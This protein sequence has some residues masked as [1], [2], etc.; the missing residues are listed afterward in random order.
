MY[1]I[2]TTTYILSFTILL[3]V[4]FILVRKISTKFVNTS[5]PVEVVLTLQRGCAP[6]HSGSQSAAYNR[7]KSTGPLVNRNMD[8][9]ASL[10]FDNLQKLSPEELKKIKKLVLNNFQ[11]NTMPRIPPMFHENYHWTDKDQNMII[12]WAQSK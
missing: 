5:V 7:R 4:G 10:R 3:L 8:N 6:C 11:S 1:K 12:N 2:S 9:I